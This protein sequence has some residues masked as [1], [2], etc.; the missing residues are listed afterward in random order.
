MTIYSTDNVIVGEIREVLR[1]VERLYHQPLADAGVTYEILAAWPGENQLHAVLLHG[2][3]CLATIKINSVKDRIRGLPDVLLTVDAEHW[4][5]SERRERL[6]LIDHEL[7]HLEPRRND[8]GTFATDDAGRPRL[9]LRPHDWQIGGFDLIVKRH[10]RAAAELRACE[11]MIRGPVRQLL[12][13][14]DGAPDDDIRAAA[15]DP[16]AG[17]IDFS[18]EKP[19]SKRKAAAT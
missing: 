13:F 3:P 19:R 9:K 11:Q 15:A 4:H 2:W 16:N 5:E 18:T 6:A 1:E 17:G 12:L 8:E 14:D 7:N 10:G